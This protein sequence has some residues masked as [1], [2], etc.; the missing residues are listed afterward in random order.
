[1]RPPWVLSALLLLVAL[2]GCLQQG[3]QA[4]DDTAGGGTWAAESEYGLK[5]HPIQLHE[6]IT[7][8]ADKTWTFEWRN[9]APPESVIEYDAAC[10]GPFRVTLV[11]PDG[12]AVQYEEPRM[13][14]EAVDMQVLEGGDSLEQAW[15]WDGRLW[16]DGEKRPAPEGTYTIR[17]GFEGYHAGNRDHRTD[18]AV[19][20]STVRVR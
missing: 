1:M 13:H 5:P 6:D 11:A 20:E 18:D 7:A 8:G 4:D 2:S 16:A 12:V 10:E 19:G 14:C 17:I 15:T 9:Q 3:G